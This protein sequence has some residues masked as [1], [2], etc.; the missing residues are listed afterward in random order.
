MLLNKNDF[1]IGL[2]QDITDANG[3]SASFKPPNSNFINPNV[4]VINAGKGGLFG[5]P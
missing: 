4:P 2:M 3:A 1:E 5:P